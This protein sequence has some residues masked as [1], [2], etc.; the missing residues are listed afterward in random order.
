MYWQNNSFWNKVREGSAEL[1]DIEQHIYSPEYLNIQ[2][3]AEYTEIKNEYNTNLKQYFFEVEKYKNEEDYREIFFQGF[4]DGV[5]DE[6]E[7][8]NAENTFI[9]LI[10]TLADMGNM[11]ACFDFS[12]PIE[13]NHPLKKSS[14]VNFDFDFIKENQGKFIKITDKS[15]LKQISILLA[16]EI[17][18]GYIIFDDIRSVIT[19]SGMHGY[20]LSDEE[21]NSDLLSS[22]ILRIFPNP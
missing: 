18:S 6:K 4:L 11:Y 17:V 14:D 20:I 15:Q 19:C 5:I 3:P 10:D 22:S 12:V 9:N 1:E 2:N 16:R 21:L 8:Y 7:Y 13:D